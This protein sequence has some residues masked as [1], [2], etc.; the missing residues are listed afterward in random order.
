MRHGAWIQVASGGAFYP[1]DPRPEEV[2]IEDIAHALSHICRFTGHTQE[3]L[4]VAQHCVHAAQFARPDCVLH[5]LLH[6]AAEAYIGDMA[7]PVKKCLM[8]WDGTQQRTIEDVEEN[9]LRVIYQ[10]LGLERPSTEE[11]LEVRRVDRL[12]LSWEAHELLS[13]LH[14]GWAEYVGERPALPALVS[15]K[16]EQAEELF[17]LAYDEFT[18]SLAPYEQVVS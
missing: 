9:I 14:P 15:W 4:S 2:H 7:T 6:D 3:F 13:P 12:L 18:A 10:A 1:L 16:P 17:L 5:A 8:F 11:A